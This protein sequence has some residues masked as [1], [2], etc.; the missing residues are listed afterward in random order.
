MQNSLTGKSCDFLLETKDTIILVECKACSFTAN[1]LTL[2]AIEK[3]NSTGQ[4]AKGL[5]Q[6]YTTAKDLENG[7]YE[8]YSINH[9]KETIGIVVTFGEIPSANSDWYFEE[10]FLKK[11][12]TKL[13]ENIYPSKQM[14]RRPLVLDISG[15]EKLI[16]TLNSDGKT[17]Q[18]LYDNKEEHGYHKTGDWGVWLDLQRQEKTDKLPSF[19]EDA[20]KEFLDELGLHTENSDKGNDIEQ[21]IH[22]AKV[23]KVLNG[24]PT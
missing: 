7:K 22:F 18:E 13:N 5:I 16:N 2:N 14:S 9:N 24:D 21:N 17:L 23:K 6:L 12:D 8:K 10:F 4:V 20:K 15:F 1:R 3:T 11:A 19:L